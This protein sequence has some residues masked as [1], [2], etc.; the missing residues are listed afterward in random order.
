MDINPAAKLATQ[1]NGYPACA[2]TLFTGPACGQRPAQRR[3]RQSGRRWVRP[4]VLANRGYA[5][6]AQS[7]VVKQT[8]NAT[9]SGSLLA[10]IVIPA[11]SQILA[12]TLMVTTAWTGASNDARHRRTVSATAF[13]A[14][15]AGTAT[16]LGIIEFS[17]APARPRSATG[18]TSA[19]QD[20]QIVVTS[21][22]TGNGVGTL[23]VEYFQMDQFGELIGRS[24]M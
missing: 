4:L 20:V 21:T 23:T 14:A 17:P 24:P 13:T 6:M 15:G 3:H 7:C 11:Q 1:P 16:T 12:I 2:G 22:N 10:R 5:Q 19:R 9:A 8:T 18:T